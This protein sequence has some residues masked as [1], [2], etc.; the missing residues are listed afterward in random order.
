[1]LLEQGHDAPAYFPAW[2]RVGAGCSLDWQR[3]RRGAPQHVEQALVLL[4]H[5]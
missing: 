1:M 2:G 5:L 4:L 3:W